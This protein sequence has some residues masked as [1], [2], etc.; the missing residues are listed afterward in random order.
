MN[1]FKWFTQKSSTMPMEHFFNDSYDP[2]TITTVR[3]ALRKSMYVSACLRENAKRIANLKPSVELKGNS[4][5][6]D[7]ELFYS[8]YSWMELKGFCVVWYKDKE[9]HVLDIERITNLDQDKEI[10]YTTNSKTFD[11]PREEI[12]ILHNYSPFLSMYGEPV[13]NKAAYDVL[14]TQ[15]NQDLAVNSFYK[16]GMFASSYITTEKPLAPEAYRLF[17]TEM[18]EMMSGPRN[19]GRMPILSGAKIVTLSMSPDQ[20]KQLA[21]DNT[22][23]EKIAMMFG[24][25]PLI[26]GRMESGWGNKKPILT[27]YITNTIIPKA[28]HLASQIDK[29]ILPLMGLKGTFTFDTVHIPELQEEVEKEPVRPQEA[30]K[31]ILLSMPVSPK[32][33]KSTVSMDNTVRLDMF[34]KRLRPKFRDLFKQ[35]GKDY[36][37]ELNKIEEPGEAK[38]IEVPGK[39]RDKAKA[40]GRQ[41]YP[42]I[43]YEA[44]QNTILT[45]GQKAFK[46]VGISFNLN[47]PYVQQVL[48]EQVIALSQTVYENSVTLLKEKVR[49]VLKEARTTGLGIT[50]TM[51]LLKEQMSSEFNGWMD[52][53]AE[54]VARTESTIANTRAST[55][56]ARQNGMNSKA[57]LPSGSSNPREEHANMDPDNFIPLDASFDVGGIAMYGPGDGPASEVVNC[58]CSLLYDWR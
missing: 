56:G 21:S 22:T 46:E 3:Q 49:M 51:K 9:L 38:M 50:D 32:V 33:N 15:S 47:D 12:A 40:I 10:T 30:K 18:K 34:T 29:F 25:P 45:Y 23:M 43:Y 16:N 48:E 17:K 31:P 8:I 26:L 57:W 20:F 42:N 55:E 52:Y 11:I 4:L 36:M 24:V 6:T 41:Y 19:A 28:E 7:K 39:Y 53:R 1:I 37:K 13:L 27:F 2:D 14:N 35:M 54:R 44:G 5:Y 58:G